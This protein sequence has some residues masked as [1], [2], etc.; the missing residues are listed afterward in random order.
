M[1]QA[2]SSSALQRFRVLITIFLAG[3][4]LLHGFLVWQVKHLLREGY[5]DFAIFYCAGKM[6]NLGLASQLYDD[7]AQYRIQRS[8]APRV[9]IRK[10]PLPYNHP[11]FEALLFAPLARLPYFSAFLVWDLFNL[12]L[13]AALPWILRPHI[14]LLQRAS[15]LASVLW[16]VPAALA[17]FPLL[18]T[19]IQGQ[20][21]VLLLLLLA[22]AYIA[23]KRNADFCAGCWLGLGLFRFHLVL[24]LALI[25][26]LR[27]RLK[28]TLSFALTGVVLGVISLAVVGWRET[29]AYPGYI[30]RMESALGRRAIVP[31]DMPNLRGLLATALSSRL[32]PA[33][34]NSLIAV[35]SL[36][37]IYFVSL[38]WKSAGGGGGLDLGY[39]LC[40]VSSIL[41]GY[42]SYVH[43]LSLLFLAS[44]LVVNYGLLTGSSGAWKGVRLYAPVFLLFF[45]PVQMVLLLR[46][47]QF[48]LFALVLLL[49]AWGI[50]GEIS[51]WPRAATPASSGATIERRVSAE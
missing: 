14:A 24:P 38:K 29:L 45:S 19:F 35:L 51:Q 7:Q 13:L 6:L 16:F 20:D 12:A 1:S 21:T 28:T 27:R 49:W 9:N 36:A 26:L 3:M 32:S 10:G 23:L 2:T 43:D 11:P 41:L 8:F 37:L 40:L 25:L 30:W 31:H 18:M 33:L 46:Y 42:H 50:S 48:Y 15:P 5:S 44:L 39:A 34:V 17:F 22:L 47:D 4:L